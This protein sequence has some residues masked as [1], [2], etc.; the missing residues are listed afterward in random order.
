LVK[1]QNSKQSA[2]T[3]RDYQQKYKTSLKELVELTSQALKEDERSFKPYHVPESLDFHPPAAKPYRN[4][5][6]SLKKQAS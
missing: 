5:M 2:S 3:D 1:Q 6:P 4:A